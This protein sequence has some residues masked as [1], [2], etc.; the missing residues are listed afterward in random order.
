MNETLYRIGMLI[1]T[2]IMM[3]FL[4]AIWQIHSF[5]KEPTL[6]LKS[7]PQILIKYNEEINKK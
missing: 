4:G 3:F 5:E 1:S 7:H 2:S 6:F